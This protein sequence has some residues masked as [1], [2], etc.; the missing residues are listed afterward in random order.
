MDTQKL[1]AMRDLKT[2]YVKIGIS[3]HPHVRAY[4]PSFLV[5]SEVVLLFEQSVEVASIAEQFVHKELGD[6]RV[7]GEW[8]AVGDDLAEIKLLFEE[9]KILCQLPPIE[10]YLDS[11]DYSTLGTAANEQLKREIKAYL[12][13]SGQTQTQLAER[14]GMSQSSLNN[15]WRASVGC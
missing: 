15:V 3:K 14:L 8:F 6:R 11:F 12:V 4:Q 9:A 7:G 2:G 10:E 13:K 5:K 1:Y